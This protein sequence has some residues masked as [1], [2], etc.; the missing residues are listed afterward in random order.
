MMKDCRQR[1]ATSAKKDAVSFMVDANVAEKRS[2]RVL[3]VIDSGCSDDLIGEK[4]VFF[5]LEKM[6]NRV[7]IKVAK[8]GEVLLAEKIGEI[9]A[10]IASI[11]A[12]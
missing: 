9:Y 8:K 4:T 7:E 3:F 10:I 11:I 12:K 2:G 6:T 1:E 5:L